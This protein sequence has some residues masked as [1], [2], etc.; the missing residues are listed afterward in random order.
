[1]DPLH[2]F[3]FE[4]SS[5][6]LGFL[7]GDELLTASL[8][9]NPWYETIGSLQL[10]MKKIKV[11][12]KCSRNVKTTKQI[13]SLLVNSLRKYENLDILR[14][15]KCVQDIEE[16]F[17][18]RRKH[19]K[20]VN[21]IKTSF[22][23]ITQA[24][25]F[26]EGIEN[27]VEELK[28]EE[29]FMDDNYLYENTRILT[30]PKLK[31]LRISHMQPQLF[32]EAFENVLNLVKLEICGNAQTV[33]SLQAIV[34]IFRNNYELKELH[35]TNRVFNQVFFYNFVGHLKFKLKILSINC[36]YEGE[37]S[38]YTRVYSNFASMLMSQA[39]SLT[40]LALSDW[41]GLDVLKAVYCLSNL[42]DLTIKGLI[43]A[44]NVVGWENINFNE[45]RSVEA[46]N[47]HN[48]PDN[49]EIMK[50]LTSAAPLVT[51]LFISL[52]DSRLMNHVSQTF[53]QLAHLTIGTL[54]VQ[55]ASDPD[56]FRELQTLSVGVCEPSLGK[57]ICMKCDKRRTYF[58]N[59]FHSLINCPHDWKSKLGLL[60]KIDLK[61]K[62]LWWRNNL[63]IYQISS[64]NIFKIKKWL[65]REL[66]PE[67]SRQ[68]GLS[69][70]K[71]ESSSRPPSLNER[72]HVGSKS[73]EK[74]H[75]QLLTQMFLVQW[76]KLEH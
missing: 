37:S 26:F 42:K 16:L 46:L 52:I 2:C 59:I 11:V 30:F 63:Q 47:L 22:L 66:N 49:F 19:W 50:Q 57:N 40:T 76:F 24:I 28:V 14:C 1:M 61:N 41:M 10:C 62:I 36:L 27:T 7:D 70:T 65:G 5:L 34:N 32:H 13:A 4:V 44:D 73:Q 33:R 64:F 74:T 54:N 45:N 6:I 31:V 48:A 3:P 67:L 43:N 58:E 75:K 39:S 21:I 35:I 29:V 38:F 69:T 8:V 12:A 18:S 72:W 25:N 60:I 23:C 55:E 17:S 51:C 15:S 71:R 20:R 68:R 9:S 56:L 53:K